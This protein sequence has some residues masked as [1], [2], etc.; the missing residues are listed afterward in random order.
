MAESFGLGP[1]VRDLCIVPMFHAMAWGLPYAAMM[2]G[3]SLIMPDRFL[4]A[5]P[6]AKMIE[7]ERPTFACAVPTIFTD[8]LAYLDANPGID[9]SSLREVVIGGSA[10][11][12]A[13]MH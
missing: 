12:P 13:L 5:A 3:A 11:P 8:L 6:L 10:C 7:V 4:M 1:Q 2:S 9:T